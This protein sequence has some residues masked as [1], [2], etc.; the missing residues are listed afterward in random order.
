MREHSLPD[1]EDD[2][3][4]LA[5]AS[6]SFIDI[7]LLCLIGL[8]AWSLIIYGVVKITILLFT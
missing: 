8:I 2:E 3:R 5:M 6:L 7:A 4:P 1:L